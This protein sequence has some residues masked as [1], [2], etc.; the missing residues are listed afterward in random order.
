[1]YRVNKQKTTPGTLA[2][3]LSSGLYAVLLA[4]LFLAATER[5]AMAYTDPGS[6]ALLLQAL[7]AVLAGILFQFRRIVSWF[8]SRNSG[9]K[10]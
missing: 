5:Q 7:F 4:L 2:K 9:P 6:G 1:M 10:G 3:T 8:K